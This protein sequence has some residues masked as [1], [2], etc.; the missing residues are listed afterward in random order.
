MFLVQSVRLTAFV[1]STTS[2][3][4]TWATWGEPPNT[5]AQSDCNIR[6]A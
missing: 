3:F 4:E 6:K 1:H 2:M 5:S